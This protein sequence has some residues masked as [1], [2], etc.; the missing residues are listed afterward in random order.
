MNSLNTMPE[1]PAGLSLEN[2]YLEWLGVRLVEWRQ[3]YAEIHLAMADRLGNR[4]G[5][6]HGGVICTLL[7]S[8]CGYCGQYA[9]ENEPP[10]RA[11]TLTLTTNFI[12]LAEGDT[13]IAKAVV[14]K[15]GKSV[16]FSRGE[17]WSGDQ[18]VATAS[19]TFK[20]TR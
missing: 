13:L 3:G 16:Y 2:P 20:Y 10:R 11:V 4:S 7:D 9:P 15:Q 1:E 12:D 5:R 17:V 19:G 8:V 18:L 6:V 14:E